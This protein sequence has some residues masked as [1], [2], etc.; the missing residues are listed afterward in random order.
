[1]WEESSSELQALPHLRGL[2][3][4]ALSSA[5]VTGP[6]E[7]EMGPRLEFRALIY[8]QERYRPLLLGFCLLSSSMHS[9]SWKQGA[10]LRMG[11]CSRALGNPQGGQ[12]DSSN[13]WAASTTAENQSELL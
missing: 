4:H 1:M 2:N 3:S 13:S 12:G 10:L 9:H 6:S 5:A 7:R 8:S 11:D